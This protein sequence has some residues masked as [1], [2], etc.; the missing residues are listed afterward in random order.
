MTWERYG[1]EQM[2]KGR[3]EGLAEG[4]TKIVENL[5]RSGLDVEKLSEMSGV[6]LEEVLK[7]QEDML[8]KA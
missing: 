6:P 8:A 2:N 1:F 4:R 3:A 7:I 5:I